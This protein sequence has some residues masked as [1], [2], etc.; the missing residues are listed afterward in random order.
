MVLYIME[1]FNFEISALQ[2]SNFYRNI[3]ILKAQAWYLKWV[4]K[5]L[6]LYLQKL[7]RTATF[8]VAIKC[9]KNAIDSYQCQLQNWRKSWTEVFTVNCP[10]TGEWRVV[11]RQCEI[12]LPMPPLGLLTCFHFGYTTGSIKTFWRLSQR[13]KSFYAQLCIM[14]AIIKKT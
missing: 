12:A 6:H 10:Q 3:F 1:L 11:C 13:C 4:K 8:F 9:R 7:T 5:P 14:W 2:F